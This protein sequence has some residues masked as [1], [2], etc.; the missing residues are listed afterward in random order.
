[1]DQ[2]TL[3]D[4]FGDKLREAPRPA[5]VFEDAA[6][7]RLAAEALARGRVRAVAA[8]W[9]EGRAAAPRGPAPARVGDYEGLEEVGRGGMGVVV[10]ARQVSL[11][12]VVALKMILADRCASP[13]QHLRLRLEAELAARVQHPNIVQVFEVGAHEGR[14]FLVM[15]WV[16]GGSLAA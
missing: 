3:A 5:G 6:E 16:G 13:E 1:L 2:L 8:T 14:P 10:R 15:E 11:N 7:R 9:V 12:R 4:A